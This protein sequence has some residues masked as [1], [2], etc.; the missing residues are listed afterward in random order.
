MSLLKRRLEHAILLSSSM[1]PYINY[2]KNWIPVSQN[3]FKGLRTIALQSPGGTVVKN[4]SANAGYARDEGL[5]PGWERSPGI[6]N[7]N[8]LQYPVWKISKRKESGGLQSMSHSQTWLSDWACRYSCSQ[9]D[10]HTTFLPPLSHLP[11][12]LIYISWNLGNKLPI[13]KEMDSQIRLTQVRDRLHY[14]AL[15]I[16]LKPPEKQGEV[17]D[18]TWLPSFFLPTIKTWSLAWMIHKVSK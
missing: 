3:V 6:G 17:W 9:H 7:G 2:Q 16:A 18:T 4:P 10:P 15:L 12:S 14:H 11:Y 5:S 8:P 1:T 13:L